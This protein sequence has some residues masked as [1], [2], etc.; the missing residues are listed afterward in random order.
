[1]KNKIIKDA[2]ALT[3]IT[4]V[5]GVA[6]G[7][8]YEITKDPIAKQEAQAKAE[9]YEQVFTDAAAFE[10][11]EMDDTLTKTI[12]DQLDQEGYK[13]QSIEEVMRAEDQS[14][15]TLGYA[16]AVVTSEG[17]GG[18]IRFSMGVQNDGTLNGISILSIGETAGL[19]M[20]ADTP[21]F[22]DQFVGKQVEKL[23]YTKN[24]A[25]QDDEIN[26][27]SGATVTT[28]AMTN[29]VNAGLCAFRVMEGGDQ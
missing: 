9:A 11:V 27:I 3:L 17:Y 4:L 22:K 25:T 24:G 20:N 21:A 1:M 6:L 10:A 28:N 13:A 7:G 5:A 8:V 29:G 16:F 18:D 23:Q 19:G 26:A 14:G 12:R 2:L 15:E